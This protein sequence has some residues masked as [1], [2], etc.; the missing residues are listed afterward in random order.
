MD[1]PAKDVVRERAVPTGKAARKPVK[2]AAP[3]KATTAPTL[4][5]VKITHPD[6]VLYKAQGLTKLDLANFYAAMADRILPHVA[7]RPLSVVRCPGGADAKCFY[8]KHPA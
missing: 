5:G 3:K 6:R 7:D 8:Q 1:K 4:H 2:A